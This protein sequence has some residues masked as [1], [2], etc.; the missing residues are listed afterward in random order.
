[1]A[2]AREQ[3]QGQLFLWP[4][5]PTRLP[6]VRGRDQAVL[7]KTRKFSR[8]GHGP[9][10]RTTTPHGRSAARGTIA[11]QTPRAPRQAAVQ[12][13]P[14]PGRRKRKSYT[15][16]RPT[17]EQELPVG[18]PPHPGGS[19]GAGGGVR[20]SLRETR[21]P[22]GIPRWH[23]AAM[24]STRRPRRKDGDD[25]ANADPPP[26]ALHRAPTSQRRRYV[27][28]ATEKLRTDG[29]GPTGS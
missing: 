10:K 16:R 25:G 9:G 24:S 5:F 29:C 18:C 14:G 23:P 2:Q 3:A 26:Q 19:Q 22:T 7:N 13:P 11:Q 21:P 6:A 20:S 8:E 28:E 27:E 4:D 15:D 1:M 17:A 12:S